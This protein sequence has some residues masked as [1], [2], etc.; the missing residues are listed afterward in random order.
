MWSA[1][2]SNRWL[3]ISALM[4]ERDGI[5]AGVSTGIRTGDTTP[6]QRRALV[7]KPPD[8]LIT[9]PESLYLMLTSKARETLAQVDTVIVDEIH[10]VAGTK[11]GAH[12]SLSLERLDALLA[13]PAQ[14]I[15]LSATVRPAE[16]VARF[17]GAR[18]R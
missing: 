15:G 18:T 5:E 7:R 12:L 9:T 6:E 10:S 13:S 2:S 14:R 8:I 11:R 16:D 4:L 1:T 17:L 3:V